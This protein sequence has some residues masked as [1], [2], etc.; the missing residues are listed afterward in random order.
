MVQ[1][2][3]TVSFLLKSWGKCGNVKVLLFLTLEFIIV[4]IYVCVCIYRHICKKKT[5]SK[6][7][8]FKCVELQ[9]CVLNDER[10]CFR[11]FCNHLITIRTKILS[12]FLEMTIPK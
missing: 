4:H 11:L 10:K 1:M 9:S 8:V 7:I 6:I 2:V 5:Y 12:E 3:S